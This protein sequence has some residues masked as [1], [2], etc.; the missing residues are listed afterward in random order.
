MVFIPSVLSKYVVYS[1]FA[2][3]FDSNDLILAERLDLSLKHLLI[4]Y[5]QDRSHSVV[6]DF[7]FY[8]PVVPCRDVPQD[9]SLDYYLDSSFDNLYLPFTLIRW[10]NLSIRTVCFL[11]M[12]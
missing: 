12:I 7:F 9:S 1:D 5:L 2:K 11:R 10:S 3:T 4:N 8:N 6:N